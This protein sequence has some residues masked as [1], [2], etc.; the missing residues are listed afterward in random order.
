MRF[1]GSNR[2]GS[3]GRLIGVAVALVFISTT[4][5]ITMEGLV[6]IAGAGS[7][8]FAKDSR[9]DDDGSDDEDSPTSFA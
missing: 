4:F 5:L 2:W 9:G 3:I 8:E 7:I 6:G 1:G